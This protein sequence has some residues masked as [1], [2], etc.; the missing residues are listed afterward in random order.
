VF[1][2]G[3]GS[4]RSRDRR[5]SRARV[6]VPCG[7]CG[8]RRGSGLTW[9]PRRG[10][11]VAADRFCLT[12]CRQPMISANSCCDDSHSVS[13][14]SRLNT[15]AGRRITKCFWFSYRIPARGAAGAGRFPPQRV[16]RAKC[17]SRGAGLPGVRAACRSTWDLASV[18]FP[19]SP[20]AIAEA[21]GGN[22]GATSPARICTAR[23]KAG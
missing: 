7:G 6:C 17:A 16:W 1:A 13:I 3:C 21:C 10:R 8:F 23:C 20:G 14:T 11:V 18:H 5:G 15:L 2:C 12:R 19:V 9:S 4:V 22:V